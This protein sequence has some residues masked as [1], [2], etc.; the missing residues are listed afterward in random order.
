MANKRFGPTD[1]KGNKLVD[2]NLEA[3]S[4]VKTRDELKAEKGRIF[5][6]LSPAAQDA[7][8]EELADELKLPKAVVAPVAQAAPA[9]KAAVATS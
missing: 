1:S 9:A 8:Y 4:D 6:H 2:V 3:F 7:A 5:G